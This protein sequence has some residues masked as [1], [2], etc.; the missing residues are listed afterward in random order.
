MPSELPEGLSDARQGWLEAANAS[1]P[2]AYADHLAEDAVWLPP[3]LPAIEG[4]QAI[5][6]WLAETMGSLS[7]D[8]SLDEVAVR[9]ADGW[10]RETGRFIAGM[11]DKG[12]GQTMDHDGAYLILWRLETDE[13]WRIDRYVDLTELPEDPPVEPSS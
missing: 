6:R 10:A 7:Y 2:D 3:G 4:R 11:T 12:T 9:M 8:L 1:D 13:A 5:H